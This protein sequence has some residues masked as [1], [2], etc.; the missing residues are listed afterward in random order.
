MR[1]QRFTNDRRIGYTWMKEIDCLISKFSVIQLTDKRISSLF[2]LGSEILV[3]WY[4]HWSKY[5]P[6][7]PQRYI[8]IS[9]I[10]IN[11][12]GRSE[13][14]DECV[15]PIVFDDRL[16]YCIDGA[17]QDDERLIFVAHEDG[18]EPVFDWKKYVICFDANKHDWHVATSR[19]SSGLLEFDALKTPISISSVPSLTSS[20]LSLFRDQDGLKCSYDH[21]PYH[22]DDWTQQDNDSAAISFQP[23]TEERR[24]RRQSQIRLQPLNQRSK[25]RT[26][27][28]DIDHTET[29]KLAAWASALNYPDF[30]LLNFAQKLFDCI[31]KHC[32][33]AQSR[34]A[35]P[36]PSEAPQTMDWSKKEGVVLRGKLTDLV[37]EPPPEDLVPVVATVCLEAVLGTAPSDV[38]VCGLRI[39]TTKDVSCVAT[40]AL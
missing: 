31:P 13:L 27:F 1:L 5:N 23:E 25:S 12:D 36:P 37:L 14:S 26:Y 10:K 9:R 34:R 6:R 38:R 4:V 29:V 8:G 33:Q 28:I 11:L 7:S 20:N 30:V 17:I 18:S 24:M 2:W 32:S 3:L 19:T 35:P 16:K 39:E 40:V 15:A 21:T 22:L